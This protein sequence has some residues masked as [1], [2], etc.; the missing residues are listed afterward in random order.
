MKIIDDYQNQRAY[1]HLVEKI[2]ANLKVNN[3]YVD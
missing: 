1:Q 2:K 3:E